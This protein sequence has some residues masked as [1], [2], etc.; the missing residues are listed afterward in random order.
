[1]IGK[2]KLEQNLQK[3]IIHFF[4]DE[5][6][7]NIYNKHNKIIVFLEY[8]HYIS[9][10]EPKFICR[11]SKLII[12]QRL[13]KQLTENVFKQ[14]NSSIFYYAFFLFNWI[15]NYIH[16]FLKVVGSMNNNDGNE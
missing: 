14:L 11:N 12:I 2:E 7:S 9:R 1:M 13:S 5:I 6:G 3:R 8:I 16:F 15:N 4:N 10:I